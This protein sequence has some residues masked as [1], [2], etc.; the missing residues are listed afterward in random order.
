VRPGTDEWIYRKF[1]T[2]EF[3]AKFVS[4]LMF[5]LKSDINNTKSGGGGVVGSTR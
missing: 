1:Q 4:T 5:S 3:E 2:G